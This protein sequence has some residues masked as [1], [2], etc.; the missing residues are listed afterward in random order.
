MTDNLNIIDNSP[1]FYFLFLLSWGAHRFD[2]SFQPFYILICVVI[3]IVLRLSYIYICYSTHCL[4]P[5]RDNVVFP[6][7]YVFTFRCFQQFEV[8][9][10]D[11]K[12]LFRPIYDEI[13]RPYNLT[14]VEE[15]RN[16]PDL[17]TE[18]RFSYFY[19]LSITVI[20]FS[21]Y[22]KQSV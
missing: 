14:R 4:E 11:T 5:L 1:F 15:V 9:N 16:L 6:S 21:V 2:C 22:V 20:R 8:A 12:N 7:I 10:R 13:C 17:R 18:I 3:Y 19:E